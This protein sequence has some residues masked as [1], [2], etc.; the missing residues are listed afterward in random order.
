MNCPSRTDDTLLHDEWNQNPPRLAP[1]LTTRQDLNGIANARETK[2]DE[3]G[4][5]GPRGCSNWSH[6]SPTLESDTEN[7]PG[8]GRGVSLTPSGMNSQHVTRRDSVSDQANRTPRSHSRQR[9][10]WPGK[11]IFE[12]YFLILPARQ[13]LGAM[14]L[15]GAL[16]LGTYLV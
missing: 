14:A 10:S 1:D 11:P 13:R 15:L 7:Y 3:N 2:N 5:T 9:S 6:I 4:P 12:Q 8:A 16:C